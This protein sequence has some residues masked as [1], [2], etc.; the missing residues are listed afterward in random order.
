MGKISNVDASGLFCCIGVCCG[1]FVDVWIGAVFTI[2]RRILRM[3]GRIIR[4]KPIMTAK[5]TTNI[6]I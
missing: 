5:I 1:D 4:Y 6:E 3:R 2:G